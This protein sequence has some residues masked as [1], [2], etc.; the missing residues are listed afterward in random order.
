[1]LGRHGR[2]F[3]EGSLLSGVTDDVLFYRYGVTES[4]LADDKG[5][6]VIARPCDIN[7][8]ARLDCI[9]MENGGHADYF[10]AET[11]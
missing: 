5:I 10:Y 2:F 4:E 8:M 7:G 11:A 9:F 3:T 1:M 6:I